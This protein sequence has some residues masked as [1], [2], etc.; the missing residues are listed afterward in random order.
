MSAKNFLLGL[1]RHL[2]ILL[3]TYDLLFHSIVVQYI[4]IFYEGDLL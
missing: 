3:G 2:K 4:K 1:E